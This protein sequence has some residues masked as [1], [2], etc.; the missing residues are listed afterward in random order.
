MVSVAY[1]FEEYKSCPILCVP[2]IRVWYMSDF[3]FFLFKLWVFYKE[4][5]NKYITICDW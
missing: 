4:S 2:L 1:M 5:E 3:F